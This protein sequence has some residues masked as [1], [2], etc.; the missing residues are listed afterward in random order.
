M[1][2][3]VVDSVTS[4]EEAVTAAANLAPDL[5][6]MDIILS[7]KMDGI[8]AARQVRERMNIPVVFLTAHADAGTVM[9]ARESEPF[10]YVMKPVNMEDLFSTIDTALHRHRLERELAEMTR[11][12]SSANDE[13]KTT[14]EELEQA[15]LELTATVSEL[16]ETRNNLEMSNILHRESEEK[17]RALFDNMA[18]GAFYQRSDGVVTDVNSS[19]LKMFGIGRDEFL[20]TA[21]LESKWDMIDESG[22]PV[23]SEGHPSITALRT[24][25]VVKDFIA[26]V[27]NPAAGSHVWMAINAIPMYREGEADPYQVFVTLHDITERKKMEQDLAVNELRKRII[28]ENMPVGMFQSTPDGK[29]VSI[30]KAFADIMG[31][32]SEEELIDRVARSSVA[33]V[34]YEDPDRR[35]KLVTEVLASPGDWKSFENRYRRKDGSTIDGLLYLSVSDDPVT[36]TQFLYGFVQDVTDRFAAERKLR[37]QN[38]FFQTLIDTIPN[39]IFYKDRYGVYTGCNT[40][41]IDFIGKERGEIIGKTVYDLGPKEVADRYHEMDEELYRH[42]GRQRYEW[43]VKDGSGE[44]RDVLFNKAVFADAA[45]EVAGIVGVISDITGH[46]EVEESLRDSLARKEVLLREINHRVKNNL[47][48]IV[49]ILDLQ[50]HEITDPATLG[51]FNDMISRIKAISLIH[52]SLCHSE[53]LAAVDITGYIERLARE[54][55]RS[56]GGMARGVDLT[57]QGP[58]VYQP[59]DLAIPCGLIVNEIVTNSLKYAF[60]DGRAEKPVIAFTVSK[61][62]ETIEISVRDNGIGL[63]EGT[64]PGVGSTLGMTLLP[65]LAQQLDGAISVYRGEGTGYTLT[66]RAT[67]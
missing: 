17:Y 7:G 10:G 49:S 52:E 31:Y 32:D 60:P 27:F 5:V 8:E 16:T 51:R 2:Y 64:E 15:N 36:G 46:R 41:F 28:F 61:S 24:G 26:G 57:M 30:N 47:Q 54:L 37:E 29:I 33:E 4:G 19:A 35:P 63:P 3:D 23:V 1:K 38:I 53:N 50:A 48:M 45:G 39:P 65:M 14:V 20:G 66:F 13:L 6:L 58:P 42:R 44:L 56:S 21:F 59:L 18:Q 62:G 55:V 43:M 12:L 25:Q 34:L 11:D 9:R 40:A 22:N 67:R